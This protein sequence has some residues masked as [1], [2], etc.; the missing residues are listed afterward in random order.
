MK[1]NTD[2]QRSTG[3]STERG[4]GMCK[5]TKSADFRS[6]AR[7][8]VVYLHWEAAWGSAHGAV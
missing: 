3:A 5:V 2:A 8:R 1:L 6:V 7:I 4:A